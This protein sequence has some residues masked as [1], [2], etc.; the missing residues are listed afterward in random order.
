MQR[1][2]INSAYVWVT[3]N[4]DPLTVN[5]DYSIDSDN[6]TVVIRE[7]IY[8]G[9]SDSIV[10]TSFATTDPMIAYRIFQDLLGR[11]HY[12]RLSQRSG[13]VL[14]QDLKASDT[15]IIV[16]DAGALTVPDPSKNR[17]GI[18]L[19][20]GERIEYFTVVGNVLGQLRRSTLGT[21]L[22]D[23]HY[24][25]ALVIDQGADQTIPYQ[26]SVQKYTTATTTASN[27]DLT[28]FITF[29]SSNYRA[30]LFEDQ[31]E[32][33]YQGQILLKPGLT[34]VIHDSD[35]SYDSTSTADSVITPAFTI[36]TVTNV[37]TLN[38]D[39]VDGAKLEVTRKIGRVWYNTNQTL[40]KNNTLQAKFLAGSPAILPR[41]ATTST[42]TPTDLVWRTENNEPILDENNEPYEGI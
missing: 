27:Y 7:G 38:F 24:A 34:P 14:A 1:P 21:G 4:G 18:I 12:K 39:P 6:R 36:N 13:T 22:K 9:P 8:T 31:V 17:P 3:Y 2:V 11:S 37:L 32:V 23:I 26:D 16:E 30:N 28:G 25:G 35:I 29:D 40:A 20:D 41:F 33:R 5:L 10:V 15:I 19:V 42:Y